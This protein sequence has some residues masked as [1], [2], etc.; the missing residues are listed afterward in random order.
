MT[1]TAAIVH[2]TGAR[3]LVTPA[4]STVN[5]RRSPDTQLAITQ[6]DGIGATA[7]PSM[8]APASGPGRNVSSSVVLLAVSRLGVSRR[9][10][11][12]MPLISW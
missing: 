12:V 7:T 3:T 10:E 1:T 2:G 9:N 8:Y 4:A 11:S 5:R 6:P